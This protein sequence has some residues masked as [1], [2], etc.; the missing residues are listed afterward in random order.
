MVAIPSERGQE[1][2]GRHRSPSARVAVSMINRPIAVWTDEFV[3]VIIL[4]QEFAPATG[5]T[6]NEPNS[7]LPATNC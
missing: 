5:S 3:I 4:I 1:H 6:A 2:L 7:G